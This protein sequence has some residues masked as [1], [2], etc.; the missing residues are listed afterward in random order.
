[1]VDYQIVCSTAGHDKGLYLVVI[2]ENEKGLLVCDGKYRAIN[3]PKQKNKN[4]VKNTGL[5]VEKEQI[6]TN[7][8]LRKAIFEKMKMYREEI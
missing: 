7:K 4:H 6:K 1:M 5:F 8:S 2:G 3:K